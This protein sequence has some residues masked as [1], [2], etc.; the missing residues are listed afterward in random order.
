MNIFILCTGRSGSSGFVKACKHITNFSAGHETLADKLGPERFNFPNNHIEADNRL[1][2]QLG[3]LDKNYGQDAFYVHLIRDKEATA[4]SYLNRFLLPKSMIYAYANGIKKSPPEILNNQERLKVCHDYV[5][6]VNTNINGFLKDKPNKM[7]I[8]LERIQTDFKVFWKA[9]KA[10]GDLEKALG[11]FNIKHNPSPK[12][13]INIKY[14]F[15]HAV[16][17]SKLFLDQLFNN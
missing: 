1:S 10:E 13:T 7:T 16:L 17:K 11:E 4:N 14:S 15:K 3:Q 6:T 2:W 12:Q 5:D 8:K 9:I